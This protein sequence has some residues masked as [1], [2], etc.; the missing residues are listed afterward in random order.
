MICGQSGFPVGGNTVIQ[1]GTI[2]KTDGIATAA[3]TATA[4]V[5]ALIFFM[6]LAL[7]VAALL[8]RE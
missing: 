8:N 7:C 5:K 6:L 3:K 1:A 4:A 2:K